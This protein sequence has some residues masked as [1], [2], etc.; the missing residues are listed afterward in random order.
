MSSIALAL[1]EFVANTS[2][3]RL[4]GEV[5]KEAKRRIADVVGIGLSG[6]T[7]KVGE[8]IT[9]YSVAKG[10]AGSA[11]IWGTGQK[12]T[13]AYAALANGSMTFHLELDDVHRTS[14]THPGVCVIPAALALCEQKGLSGKELLAAVVAGY[15]VLIRIGMGVSPSIYVDRVFLAPG[16]LGVFGAAAAAAKLQG[17]SPAEIAG[18]IGTS[19][20]LGPIAPFESFSKGAPAKETIMGWC[21]M[22]GIAAVDLANYG[23]PGPTT[24]IEGEFGYCKAVS[25]RYDLSRI[26]SKLGEVFEIMNTGVKPYACCRQHHSA[27]DAVLE[28]R[29]KEGLAPGKIKSIR[30]RTFKV[31]SRGSDKHPKTIGAAKYSAPYTI[32]VTFLFGKAW[33]EQ[34]T[35]ELINDPVVSGLAAKVEVSA[36]A[37]LEKLYDE[38]WPAIVEVETLDGRIFQARRDIPKGEPEYPVS[39]AE[40]RQK[41]MSLAADAVSKEKADEVWKMIFDVENLKDVSALTTALKFSRTKAVSS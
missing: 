32:A 35:L 38:K 5:I 31:A 26:T 8:N 25:E 33:R 10:G 7:S 22:L 13:P 34:Y 30:C 21:G 27:I 2:Y 6:A 4:P 41:F 40:L 11:S 36:D 14:H 24:A 9:R 20:Y 23:F 17:L 39:D 29:E 12:T 37:D 19:S 3:S 18:V 15:D 28:I 1:A 16:T